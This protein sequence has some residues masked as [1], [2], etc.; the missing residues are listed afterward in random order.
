MLRSPGAMRAHLPAVLPLAL[1]SLSF[2][3]NYA[4]DMDADE[5]DD[6]GDDGAVDECACRM[7]GSP[8]QTS[9]VP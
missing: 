5:D 1:A 8:M 6:D 4:E 3:P 9:L 7:L 2:D